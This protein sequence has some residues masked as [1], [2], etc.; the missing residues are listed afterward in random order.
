MTVADQVPDIFKGSCPGKDRG[1]M[2]AVVEETLVTVH[3]TDRGVG[4]DDAIEAGRY[5][6]ECAGHGLDSPLV[7]AG[8]QY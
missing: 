6:D 2:A 8:D 7:N 5:V 1:V 4:G 3:R